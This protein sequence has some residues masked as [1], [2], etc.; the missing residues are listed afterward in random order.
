MVLDVECAVDVG[1]GAD[2]CETAKWK[3]NRAENIH[4]PF[5]R[6]ERAV[7]YFLRM[8]SWRPYTAR[9]TTTS[10]RNAISYHA[11][12][13]RPAVSPLSISGVNAMR[14][15]CAHLGAI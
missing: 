4:Q 11:K 14:S 8:R 12:P 9:S 5:R 7:L 1:V 15:D 6:R 3:N 13:S 10:T 2:R